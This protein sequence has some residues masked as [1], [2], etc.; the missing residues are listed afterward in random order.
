MKTLDLFSSA[1]ATL[2]LNPVR[3]ALTLL[4]ILIGITAVVTVVAIGQG[5]QAAIEAKIQQLGAN[6]II[7]SPGLR[8]AQSGMMFLKEH[9]LEGL[10]RSATLIDT[11]APQVMGQFQIHQGRQSLALPCIGTN[12]DY[13]HTLKLRLLTGRFLSELDVEQRANVIV[14]NETAARKLFPRA[15]PEPGATVT[16]SGVRFT[17]IGI[18][19][20]HWF[21]GGNGFPQAY[22][23]LTTL[24]KYTPM[25]DIQQAFLQIK[26]AAPVETGIEEVSAYLRERYPGMGGDWVHRMTE[27]LETSQELSRLA[28][29]VMAGVAGVSLLVGG[30]GI[31]NVLLVG[32]RERVRE[33]GL[34]K[35]IGATNRHI[36]MQFLLEGVLICLAGGVLG[37]I[38]GIGAAFLAGNILQLPVRISEWALLIGTGFACAV[39][40]IFSYYPASQAARLDPISALRTE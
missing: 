29:L 28:T 35:A 1:F 21:S 6:L 11:L 18:V 20:D 25:G 2:R 16:L 37:V 33:I 31:M 9:D 38:L 24:R 7:L 27:F 10:R 4:G 15:W 3:T 8:S 14:L 5:N 30:I 40:L 32:V 39:G 26:S 17:L 19:G 23:P 22:M 12:G 34:R 36:M 13:R